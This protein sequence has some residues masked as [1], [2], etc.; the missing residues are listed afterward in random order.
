[1]ENGSG[2]QVAKTSHNAI[3]NSGKERV[4]NDM[5]STGLYLPAGQ[6]FVPAL[7]PLLGQAELPSGNARKGLLP[8]PDRPS[9]PLPGPEKP[10]LLVAYDNGVW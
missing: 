5:L 8:F 1:M 4:G 2:S 7:A 6:L 3:K 9:L 10:W